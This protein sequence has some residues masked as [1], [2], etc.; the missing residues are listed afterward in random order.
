MVASS[1]S[2]AKDFSGLGLLRIRPTWGDEMRIWIKCKRWMVLP[3]TLVITV[4]L[5][6]FNMPLSRTSVRSNEMTSALHQAVFRF[7]TRIVFSC[8]EFSREM[9]RRPSVNMAMPIENQWE[10]IK[11]DS[12]ILR[13]SVNAS[14]ECLVQAGLMVL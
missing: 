9:I 6:G 2:I 5:S 12:R 10:R 8:E 7:N 4:F 14:P 13:S 1:S 11:A 3:V